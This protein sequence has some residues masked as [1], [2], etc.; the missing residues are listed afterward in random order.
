MTSVNVPKKVMYI[1]RSLFVIKWQLVMKYFGDIYYMVDKIRSGDYYLD[2][3]RI[4]DF[5]YKIL[6]T[7]NKLLSL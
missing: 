5:N 4:H 1:M 2:M 3:N 6:T 7:G